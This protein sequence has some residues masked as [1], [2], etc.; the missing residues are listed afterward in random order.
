MKKKNSKE[1]VN[2]QQCT[3]LEVGD[4][5]YYKDCAYEVLSIFHSSNTSYIT[6]R[7]QYYQSDIGQFAL[8]KYQIQKI[9][10]CNTI[11]FIPNNYYIVNKKLMMFIEYKDNDYYFEDVCSLKRT[12]EYIRGQ[13]EIQ[14]V[15]QQKIKS[16]IEF[17]PS[18][19]E[20]IGTKF[21][22]A[23]FSHRS[24]CHV[25]T[26]DRVP[27][28]FINQIKDD[29]SVDDCLCG[30]KK[31]NL[32]RMKIIIDNAKIKTSYVYDCAFIPTLIYEIEE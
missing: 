9:D 17:K 13:H 29:A 30:S 23:N 24:F 2:K 1:V 28:I 11:K 4:F 22:A 19:K 26:C 12:T 14:E 8:N 5:F 27:A 3:L 16:M 10:N 7:S 18:H 32:N 21:I 31:C 20:I 6:A 25:L 15:D